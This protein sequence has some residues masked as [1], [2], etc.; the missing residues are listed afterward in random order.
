MRHRK[1]RATLLETGPKKKSTV[2][3]N[4]LTSLVINGSITTTEAKAR[5]LKTYADRFFSRLMRN[6]TTCESEQAAHRENIRLVKATIYGEDTGKKVIREL[7]PAYK[8][9][10]RTSFISTYRV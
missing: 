7:I 8:D 9:E 4:M 10:K 2:L 5:A 3:R 1:K 6:Y